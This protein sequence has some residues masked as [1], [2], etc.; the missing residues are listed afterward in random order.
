[1]YNGIAILNLSSHKV[2]SFSFVLSYFFIIIRMILK[3]NSYCYQIKKKASVSRRFS[4]ISHSLLCSN[5]NCIQYHRLMYILQESFLSLEYMHKKLLNLLLRRT[6]FL[7]LV[8]YEPNLLPLI[9]QFL[10]Q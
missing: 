3:N 7:Q 1:M 10:H 9:L 2:L 8:I 4:S 6:V 5:L